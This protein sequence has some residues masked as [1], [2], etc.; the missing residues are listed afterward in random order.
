MK[1]AEHRTECL[2]SGMLTDRHVLH[3]R[4][5][6]EARCRGKS[7]LADRLHFPRWSSNEMQVHLSLLFHGFLVLTFR[8]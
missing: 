7:G 8:E 4:L 6:S 5:G 2:L 3:R 1:S